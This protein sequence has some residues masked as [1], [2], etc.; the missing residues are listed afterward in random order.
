MSHH[1]SESGTLH[2][3]LEKASQEVRGWPRWMQ[4]AAAIE[5]EAR[6]PSKQMNAA[7]HIG[8]DNARQA[9]VQS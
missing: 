4:E 6:K 5:R 9:P 8:H 3:Q 2:K 7:G 1:N